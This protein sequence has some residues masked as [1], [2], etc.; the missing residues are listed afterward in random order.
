MSPSF[1]HALDSVRLRPYAS[2]KRLENADP[3]FSPSLS[4]NYFYSGFE[5]TEVAGDLTHSHVTFTHSSVR[6]NH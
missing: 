6:S 3:S 4:R 2:S 1:R 5:G